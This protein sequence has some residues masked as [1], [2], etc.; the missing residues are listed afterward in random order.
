MTKAARALAAMAVGAVII[1]LGLVALPAAQLWKWWNRWKSRRLLG[2]VL[3][4]RQQQQ[5]T[6]GHPSG[7]AGAP[8]AESPPRRLSP[9]APQATAPD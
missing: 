3:R 9:P 5:R 8:R 2:L 4:Q 1:S 6:L 7:G